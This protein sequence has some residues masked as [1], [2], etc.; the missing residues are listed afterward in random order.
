MSQ[1]GGGRLICSERHYSHIRHHSSQNVQL[2]TRYLQGM[3]PPGL[4]AD[5]KSWER[6]PAG[7]IFYLKIKY[8][9]YKPTTC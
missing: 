8:F 9:E 1:L 3:I 6:A 2:N 4:Q 5:G 7:N